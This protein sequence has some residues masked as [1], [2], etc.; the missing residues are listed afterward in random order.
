MSREELTAELLGLCDEGTAMIPIGYADN[1]VG[2]IVKDYETRTCGKCKYSYKADYRGWLE[3]N[4]GYTEELTFGDN[5]SLV[6][7][8]FGCNKFVRKDNGT[9]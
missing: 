4:Q 7:K 9:K 5:V 8:S 1:F 6:S 3:C 2:R